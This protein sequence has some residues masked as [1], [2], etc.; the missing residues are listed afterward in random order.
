MDEVQRL[1]ETTSGFDEGE[2][3]LGTFKNAV[4]VGVKINDQDI[5]NSI[6]LNEISH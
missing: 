1:V 4:I 6:D 2:S 5:I 3:G